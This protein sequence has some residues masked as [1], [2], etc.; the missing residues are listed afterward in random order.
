[1]REGRDVLHSAGTAPGVAVVEFETFAL[2]DECA[3][4]I[5]GGGMVSGLGFLFY[6]DGGG[7][8]WT[9]DCGR[10]RDT[11]WPWTWSVEPAQAL[12]L[13]SLS[14]DH[15]QQRGWKCRGAKHDF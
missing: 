5:L 1:M 7:R 9:G 15:A 3:E 8:W 10:E 4:A 13:L 6:E 11:P 12:L 14:K 2:E